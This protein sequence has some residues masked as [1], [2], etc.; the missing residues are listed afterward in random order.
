MRAALLKRQREEGLVNEENMFLHRKLQEVKPSKIVDRRVLGAHFKASRKLLC[1][2]TPRREGPQSAPP[3]MQ[4]IR[5]WN[6]RW[7]IGV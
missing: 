7:Q 5:V 4:E 1:K 3:G 6:D 2:L